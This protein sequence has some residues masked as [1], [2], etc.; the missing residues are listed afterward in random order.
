MAK[1]AWG[2][3]KSFL[4]RQV[5]QVAKLRVHLHVVVIVTASTD[6]LVVFPSIH[7]TYTIFLL[8][9]VNAC[10][11]SETSQLSNIIGNW[12]HEAMTTVVEASW[13]VMAH[14]QKPDFVFR[15]NRRVH[16]NRRGRQF[17]RLL[18]AEVCASAFVVGSN[19]GYTMLR[20]SEKGTGYSLHSPV[21]PTLPHSC[22]TVCHYI[23]TGVYTCYSRAK[24]HAYSRTPL[25]E[26]GS[27]LCAT[28][29]KF[30][31]SSR[32]LYDM[33]KLSSCSRV[34]RY[35]FN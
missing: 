24:V 20:G 34:L 35:I 21:S 19:A 30:F 16:L 3:C 26:N 15:R 14:A 22:V 23:S 7:V 13:N 27:I 8:A 6:R 5:E 9:V 10:H 33:V 32:I 12:M 2:G 1:F 11:L 25:D 4:V 31:W 28:W 18:A 29:W 17:S